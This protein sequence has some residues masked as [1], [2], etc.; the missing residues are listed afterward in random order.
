[1]F[2]YWTFDESYKLAQEFD[3]IEKLF[4]PFNV[5]LRVEIEHISIADFT[6]QN[7]KDQA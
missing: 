7:Q 4:D 6:I 1:M 5:I 2:S 3:P